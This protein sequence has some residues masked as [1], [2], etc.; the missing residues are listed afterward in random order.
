MCGTEPIITATHSYLSRVLSR[1]NP[2]E[3]K[4][5]DLIIDVRAF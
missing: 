4:L 1:I 3:K 2:D 5:K